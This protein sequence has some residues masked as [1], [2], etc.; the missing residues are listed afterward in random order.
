[1]TVLG[2]KRSWHH[3]GD[4][5]SFG[6]SRALHLKS[7]GR[8]LVHRRNFAKVYEI[9]RHSAADAPKLRRI[10]CKL[11][12]FSGHQYRRFVSCVKYSGVPAMK[13]L[14]RLPIVAVSIPQCVVLFGGARSRR[15]SP[16]FLANPV[17]RRLRR[18]QR[19]PSPGRCAP[20]CAWRRSARRCLPTRSRHC[21]R[22]T[23]FC[24]VTKV[25][26]IRLARP[27]I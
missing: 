25:R 9:L 12:A 11:S 27:N 13:S 21:W 3:S 23:S 7:L 4:D 14:L 24:W 10:C 16:A 20:S 15:R 5:L 1:M 17:Q 18:R 19:W 6:P 22:A 8:S 26:R 2:H